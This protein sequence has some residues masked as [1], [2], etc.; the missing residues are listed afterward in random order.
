M[1]DIEGMECF[2]TRKNTPHDRTDFM[3]SESVLCF[4]FIV[5]LSACKEFDTDVYGVERFV[6]SEYLHEVFV[7]E[8]AHDGNFIDEGFLAVFLR[9]SRLLAEGFDGVLLAIEVAAHQIN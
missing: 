7:V 6:D 4:D 5:E 2:E 8:F 9:V 3:G 1:H